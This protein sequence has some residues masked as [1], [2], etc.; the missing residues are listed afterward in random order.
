MKHAVP[1]RVPFSKYRRL[2]LYSFLCAACLQLG[3]LFFK[4]AVDAQFRLDG[5]GWFVLCSLC[6]FQMGLT[7]VPGRVGSV[8]GAT[9]LGIFTLTALC[10]LLTLSIFHHPVTFMVLSTTIQSNAQETSEFIATY[11]LRF[12]LGAALGV[13]LASAA[14]TLY[15]R[16]QRPLSLR[17]S[18]TLLLLAAV[19]GVRPLYDAG[20]NLH[21]L[22]HQYHELAYSDRLVTTVVRYQAITRERKQARAFW[23]QHFANNQ[24][25]RLNTIASQAQPDM[26]VVVLGESTTRRHMGIYGYHRPTTPFLSSMNEQLLIAR[27]AVAPVANTLPAVLG[28]LCSAEFDVDTLACGG[29]TLLGI[30][31]AGGYRTVWLSNQVPGGFGDNF[32]AELG[33][34]ADLSVFVNTDVSSGGEADNSL[35][36]DEKILGPLDGQI[37]AAAA[38]RQKTLL[39]IHLMGTHF[40]Y[41][42]R[43]PRD[44]QHFRGEEGVKS[45]LAKTAQAK[46]L[47]NRYDNAVAYQD[48]ILGEII[49]R[50]NASGLRSVLVYFSDHGEEV[51]DTEG[52]A[53]HSEDRATPAM[54][55]VP[56]V[57]AFSP[58]YRQ[59]QRV[60]WELM[61]SREH[62][63]F[64]T[65]Q[66]TPTVAKLLGLELDAV[67][68][69]EGSFG[70]WRDTQRAS[71]YPP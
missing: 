26:M 58:R 40:V 16:T 68:G 20:G 50:L 36:L 37:R 31:K 42:K 71:T 33:R 41:D 69:L 32:V 21:R 64:S 65:F 57:V 66:V 49:S 38:N 48:K 67:T 61:K 44:W 28:S 70:P 29:P 24:S 12:F 4:L 30:A 14:L 54:R 6:L 11:G 55:E 2:L 10:N 62:L 7:T 35:S 52:F 46:E 23:N 51:Y 43:Y 9:V 19:C 17:P 53:G 59:E 60:Q 63:P 39:L 34:S 15:R 3:P 5:Q 13:F 1:Q 18:L 56:F 25:L 47:V 45:R 8:V 27:R 22:A